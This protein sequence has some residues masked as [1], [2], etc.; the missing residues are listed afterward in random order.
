MKKSLFILMGILSVALFGCSSDEGK[1]QDGP[2]SRMELNT[3]QENIN[4]HEIGVAF[5]MFAEIYADANDRDNVLFSPL[6]KDLCMGLVANALADNDR[7]NITKHLGASTATALNEFNR[8]RLNYFTYKGKKAKVYFANSI[9]ANQNTMRS[10]QEFSSGINVI[11]NYYDAECRTLDFAQ[12]DVMNIINDWC[13]D[14]TEGLITKFLDKAP[15]PMAT[16]IFINAMYFKCSWET[17][18][19]KAATQKESFY[20]PDGKQRRNSANM[21]YDKRNV[22]YYITDDYAAFT[23]P[24]DE[25][26][27]SAVFVLPNTNKTIADILPDVKDMLLERQLDN[28]EEERIIIEIPR[29]K[30]DFKKYITEYI[31][32]CGINLNSVNMLGFDKTS[33]DV[34]QATNLIVEEEGTTMAATTGATGATSARPESIILNRPFLML[35]RDNNM[36]SILMMAAIQSPKE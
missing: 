10:E 23:L 35:I 2:K 24:Y 13:A 21:M 32:K 14:K 4:E 8:D 25:C 1:G 5:D 26:N 19:K 29:F 20:A 16:S 3:E 36:G 28:A 12:S 31:T 22:A 18:F 11:K 27:Y 30:V 34:L 33:F 7:D 17:P 6:S 15:S 9:W